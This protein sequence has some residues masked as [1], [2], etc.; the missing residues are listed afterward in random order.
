MEWAP[1]APWV[2]IKVKVTPY[3]WVIIIFYSLAY[4]ISALAATGFSPIANYLINAYDVDAVATSSLLLIFHLMYIPL[5]FPANY[6][7]DR[8]GMVVPTLISSFFVVFGGWVWLLVKGNTDFEWIF[9]GAVLQAVGQSFIIS[10]P[11]KLAIIWFGD[12]ERAFCTT[13]GSLASPFG[14]ILGFAMPLLFFSYVNVKEEWTYEQKIS[15]RGTIENYIF[16]QNIVITLAYLPITFLIWN[17]P[18]FVPS[19]TSYKDKQSA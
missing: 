8:Y 6:L 17:R 7:M 10:G 2:S 1:W 14:S 18:K 15:M 4:A 5:N 13:I 11:P 16:W 9:L 12:N 19:I 3:R